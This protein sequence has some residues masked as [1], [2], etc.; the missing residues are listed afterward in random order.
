M[1]EM[2]SLTVRGMYN[3]L[4]EEVGSLVMTLTQAP[5]VSM[6]WRGQTWIEAERRILRCLEHELQAQIGSGVEHPEGQ[7]S[8]PGEACVQHS[9]RCT[10]HRNQF[11]GRQQ[12]GSTQQEESH[13]SLELDHR[14]IRLI[15]V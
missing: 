11:S 13:S 10:V 14:L 6:A 8:G 4:P 2:F 9:S 1:E 5:Q 7:T 15:C 12:L 3:C